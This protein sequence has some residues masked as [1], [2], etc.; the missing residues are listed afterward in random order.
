VI[1]A[2]SRRALAVPALQPLNR[3]FLSNGDGH[4]LSMK[5]ALWGGSVSGLS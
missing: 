3:A 1:S 4:A 2:F 5:T